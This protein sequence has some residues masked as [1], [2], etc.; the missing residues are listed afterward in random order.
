MLCAPLKFTI[1]TLEFRISL[2]TNSEA[3][4]KSTLTYKQNSTYVP[5]GGENA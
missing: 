1:S 4:E 3:Q 2:L 5:A